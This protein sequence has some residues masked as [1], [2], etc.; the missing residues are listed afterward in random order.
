MPIIK[1]LIA[2]LK[3][4]TP[5]SFGIKDISLFCQKHL[6]VYWWIWDD[7]LESKIKVKAH[8]VA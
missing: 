6:K 3:I 8:A 1:F 7:L 4:A 2:Y 5:I